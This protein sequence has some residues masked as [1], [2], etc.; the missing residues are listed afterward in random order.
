MRAGRVDA[1]VFIR[2]MAARERL[3]GLADA[4]YPSV[5]ILAAAF[6]VVCIETVGV[7]QSEAEIARISDTTV[8]VTQPGAGDIVQYMK[9]G[10][11]ET[12]DIL[13]VNKADRGVEA[14]RTAAELSAA[15][16]LSAPDEPWPPPVVLVSAVDGRGIPE[17]LDALERHRRHLEESG[18]LRARRR[19][20]RETCVLEAL[21]RRYGSFGL[22]RIGG[23]EAVS[24]RLDA[25]DAPSPFALA[26]E[27]SRDIERALRS[28]RGRW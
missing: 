6:D 17:L 11:L 25:A 13:V 19:R 27:L 12:P 5:A 7:G 3:G 4:T 2:S 26:D 24:R 10:V 18:G 20:A 15:F 22:E 1:G 8:Y 23:P 9:A 28:E 21:T 14:E 16:G